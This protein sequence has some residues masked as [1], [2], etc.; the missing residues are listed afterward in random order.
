MGAKG[1]W[2]HVE[3]SATAIVL[4]AVSNSVP[5]LA[6]R[7]TP[8]ME[9]LIE[10][11]ESKIIKFEKREYLVWHILLSTTYTH[12]GM[13]IKALANAENMWK[14]VKEDATSKNIL[15]LLDAEDWLSSMK[16]NNNDDPKTH[17]S[18][19]KTTLPIDASTLR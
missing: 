18:E 14:A 12:L 13:K 1:L 6:D 3:G 4:Y 11:K 15:Y 17:L 19:L 7:K 10:A 2:R 16:L 5:M 8:A 9:D